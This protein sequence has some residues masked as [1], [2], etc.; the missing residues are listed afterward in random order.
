MI[1]GFLLC[2]FRGKPKFAPDIPML[3]D[4]KQCE[5]CAL[6]GMC[7]RMT[8]HLI[9]DHKLEEEHAYSTVDWIFQH[10]DEHR[11]KNRR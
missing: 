1:F 3:R 5:R 9:D 11:R 6:R 4:C 10:I 2:L 8:V 7:N